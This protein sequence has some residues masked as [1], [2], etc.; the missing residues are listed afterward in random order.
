MRRDC[1]YDRRFRGIIWK[2]S[3]IKN[4]TSSVPIDRTISHIEQIL[5]QSGASG[6]IK[7][8]HEGKLTA[9]CF[10][11]ALP[12]G[13]LV[14]V[15]LPVNQEAVYQTLRKEIRRPRPGTLEKLRD[16]AARTSWKLMQDWV[17]VQISLIKMQQV[18]FMQVFLPY[19][20][21]GRR[22]FYAALKEKEYLALP[23]APKTT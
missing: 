23:E 5:A 20:W 9:L 13:R 17:E 4:Y 3:V 2:K 12:T 6:I 7:D 21:D 8:Y 22:T 19:V 15:R 1:F 10:R 16:Q 18:D 11:V 14:A